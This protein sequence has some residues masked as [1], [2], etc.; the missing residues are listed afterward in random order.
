M[1]FKRK[2]ENLNKTIES[3]EKIE[4]VKSLQHV[5]SPLK[6]KGG[7]F[8]DLLDPVEE[9][10]QENLEMT[11]KPFKKEIFKEKPEENESEDQLAVCLFQ[12]KNEEQF[13]YKEKK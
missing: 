11:E 7:K 9:E 1:E 8:L 13:E 6:P 10:K 3:L 4:S 2:S 12:M 5:S